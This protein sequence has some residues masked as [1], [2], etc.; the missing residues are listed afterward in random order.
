MKYVRFEHLITWPIYGNISR[1]PNSSFQNNQGPGTVD[2]PGGR[3]EPHPQAGEPDGTL[4]AWNAI[5]VSPG[6]PPADH[7]PIAS[8]L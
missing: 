8:N 6:K 7:L 4:M 1:P 3:T 5:R 2:F